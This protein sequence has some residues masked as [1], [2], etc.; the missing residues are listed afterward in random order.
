MD[1]Y[2][3]VD[4]LINNAGILRDASFTKMTEADWN[5]I[6]RVHVFGA[7]AVTKAA[8]DVMRK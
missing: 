7:F 3:R 1:A 4:V 2:G 6:Q 8:W 5:I